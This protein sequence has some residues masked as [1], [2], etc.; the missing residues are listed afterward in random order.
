M[1]SFAVVLLSILSDISMFLQYGGFDE[2]IIYGIENFGFFATK[3]NLI[4]I[5]IKQSI[6]L[7]ASAY[8]IFVYP[9][10]LLRRKNDN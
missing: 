5:F 4:F 1:W 6:I 9:V 2:Y 8:L 7:L 3:I 10:L